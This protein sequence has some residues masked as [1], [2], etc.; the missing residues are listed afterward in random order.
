[1][2]LIDKMAGLRKLRSAE[3]DT[4][5][6]LECYQPNKPEICET[7]SLN[8]KYPVLRYHWQKNPVTCKYGFTNCV[9]DPGYI[10]KEH[11]NWYKS[12]YGDKPY[13]DIGCPD[14]VEGD[15]YDDEDK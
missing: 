10:W 14:C 4:P 9:V 3:N 7:C 6:Q 5:C 15:N 8:P 11:P 13:E 1:M 2:G 12:M